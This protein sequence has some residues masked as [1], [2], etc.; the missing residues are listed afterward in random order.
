MGETSGIEWTDCTFNPWIGCTK[1]AVGCKN[2]Y[3]E[4]FAKRYNKA[5]WGPHGTRVK[6]SD[7][8]WRQPLKWNK[9]AERDGLRRR[10]FCASLADV[11]EDWNGWIVDHHGVRLHRCCQC[12][13][14][15]ASDERNDPIKRAR[16]LCECGEVQG[17]HTR[18]TM[19][20][21]R[22]DLFGLIDQTPW[23]DWLLLTKRPENVRLMMANWL[24][25][26]CGPE[27]PMGAMLPV[28]NLWLGTSIATQEDADRNI[29]EL[30]KCGDLARVLFVSAEPLMEQVD[31]RN[32]MKHPAMPD[33][34][35]KPYSVPVEY[36]PVVGIDWLIIGGESG[37]R[38][39]SFNPA[40]AVKIIDQC[41]DSGARVFVKQLGSSPFAL[42]LKDPKGGNIKEWP[43][44]L[45]VRE[46]PESP[47][48]P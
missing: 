21:L 37:P 40:W 47:A 22:R 43:D 41:R 13:R 44:R 10:V 48:P 30:L 29:P 12:F 7:E 45:R 36:I 26:R 9:Q 28:Q 24:K 6:T 35:V 39:R 5:A 31:L 17:E 14:Q 18:L 8:Y 23:L 3:A 20:E 11:F 42:D 1:V 27:S 33:H 32:Y 15:W 19:H 46:F 16:W 25:S 4:A 2:C 38:A 34:I